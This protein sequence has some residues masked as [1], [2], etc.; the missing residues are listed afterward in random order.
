MANK[1]HS[2]IENTCP[3]INEVISAIESV[4]W[5]DNT[6]WD[7]KIVTDI[8]EKIREANQE[9]RIWGNAVYAEKEDLE[10]QVQHLEEE[11]A[12]LKEDITHYEIEN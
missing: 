4:N 2:G 1:D 10:S 9:L 11:V 3:K 5:D 8:L 7:A 6:F 12:R